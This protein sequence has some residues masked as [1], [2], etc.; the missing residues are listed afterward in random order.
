[1]RK[2]E[3]HGTVRLNQAQ[4]IILPGRDD[5]F[6]KPADW[7]THLAPGTLSVDVN[8]LEQETMKQLH[9]ATFRPALVI[10]A[11]HILG[12]PLQPDSDHP[13]RG[14]ASVWRA[15]L[16]V[17]ATGQAGKCW[18]FRIIGSDSKTEIE[19]VAEDDLRSR[20]NV[21]DGAAVKVT[22]W[23]QELNWK[24]P[25]PHEIIAEWIEAARGVEDDYG[26]EKAMGYVIGEKFLNFLEV[27][28]KNREWRE[29]IPTFVAEIK[30][31]FEPWKLTEFLNTPCRLG[32][33][34][35]TISEEDHRAFREQM[36]EEERI[37]E[38]ARNLML[39][40]WAKELLIKE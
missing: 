13:T 18:M 26:V 32:P 39:L 30:A 34:A 23:E 20:F 27:A 40:E 36:T 1:M 8:G 37:R 33:I 24:P 7:P 25:T 35:H 19:L 31:L 17:I 14:F 38:D 22:V 21:G 28:E 11:R 5:L 10:P 6:L 2:L 29:A 16:Q 9:D 15:E 3:S 12:S 4:E